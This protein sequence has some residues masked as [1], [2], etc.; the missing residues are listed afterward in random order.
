VLKSCARIVHIL[1]SRGHQKFFSARVL[2]EFVDG[3]RVD[4]S[5]RAASLDRA[6]RVR[7]IRPGL[8]HRH[9]I[10]TLST[11]I[12]RYEES[13]AGRRYSIEVAAVS[14][15]RWRAYIVRLPGVP[16]ALMPFYGPTPSAAAERLRQWLLNAHAGA[17]GAQTVPAT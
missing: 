6:R 10:P 12:H 15:D 14:A 3:R 13:I 17:A 16:T 11:V 1:W 5:S 2:S 8:D 4:G 9:H 7:T